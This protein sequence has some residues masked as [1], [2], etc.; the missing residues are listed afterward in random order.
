[1][2]PEVASH[3]ASER[4]AHVAG[5]APPARTVASHAAATS[6]LRGYG[7]PCVTIVDSSATT[8]VLS[9]RACRTSA[10]TERE[11]RRRAIGLVL[12]R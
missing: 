7:R 4:T 8:G 10:E 9:K 1:M 5:T 3:Q 2:S 12:G 6:R 11:K